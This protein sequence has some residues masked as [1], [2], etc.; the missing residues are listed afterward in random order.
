MPGG[1]YD[2]NTLDGADGAT[3]SPNEAKYAGKKG[4]GTYYESGINNSKKYYMHGGNGGGAAA[5]RWRFSDNDG[6]WYPS[7]Q[8][9]YTSVGGNG[10]DYVAETYATD[11]VLGGGGGSG[12]KSDS[13]RSGVGGA[14]AVVVVFYT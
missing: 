12:Y 11:G 5:F 8:G 6:N 14:G 3:Y 13:L 10:Q 9:Y 2:A 1:S 4:A 7:T